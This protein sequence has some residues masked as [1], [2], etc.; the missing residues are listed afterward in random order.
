VVGVAG[1]QYRDGRDPGEKAG[2]DG[3]DC[4]VREAAAG[5][6]DADQDR[7]EAVGDGSRALGGDDTARV[8]VQPRSS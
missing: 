1:D 6:C 4:C 2:Q 7:S 5:E 3:A 8:R